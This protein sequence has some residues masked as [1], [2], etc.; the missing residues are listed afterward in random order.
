MPVELS[1]LSDAAY[2]KQFDVL[3]DILSVSSPQREQALATIWSLTRPCSTTEAFLV[4]L[5]TLT[6]ILRE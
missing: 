5:A 4:V 6:A 1:L 2:N 3:C